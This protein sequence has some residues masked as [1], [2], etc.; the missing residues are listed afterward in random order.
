MPSFQRQHRMPMVVQSFPLMLESTVRILHLHLKASHCHE[1]K[2]HRKKPSLMHLNN[3]GIH[4][5]CCV[6]NF[7]WGNISNPV[8]IFST[9]CLQWLLALLTHHLYYLCDLLLDSCSTSHNN[10]Q[11]PKQLTKHLLINTWSSR[12]LNP[13]A[14]DC[15]W[16]PRDH[17]H[18][19][20]QNS[21][22]TTDE[23]AAPANLGNTLAFIQSNTHTAENVG[24]PISMPTHWITGLTNK[25]TNF[26]FLPCDPQIKEDLQQKQNRS[27]LVTAV[28]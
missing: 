1:P 16:S 11:Y 2:P 14:S 3:C 4:L 25:A 9:Q 23:L 20:D 18:Q 19:F 8:L 7:L 21:S 27:K 24:Q 6:W 10:S 26:S 13:N 12:I 22:N 28:Q 5:V 15:P 17:P